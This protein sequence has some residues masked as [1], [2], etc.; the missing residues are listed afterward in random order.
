M[1]YSIAESRFI[2]QK[3]W[4][5]IQKL[6]KNLLVNHKSTSNYDEYTNKFYSCK[7]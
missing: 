2:G 6:T 4:L 1:N 5:I 3:V 7:N